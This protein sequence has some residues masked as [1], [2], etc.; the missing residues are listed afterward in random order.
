MNPRPFILPLAIVV[1]WELAGRLGLVQSELMAVPT[2]IARAGFLAI[3]DGSM[4]H[5]T[6]ETAVASVWGTAIGASLGVF[7]GMVFGLFRLSSDLSR[8][9]LEILRPIPSVALIPVSMLV[10]GFGFGMEV[11][12]VAF[13]TF[14]PPLIVTE[15]AVRGIEPQLLQVARV[16]GF[17][18]PRRL[19]KIILPAALPRIF[20]ALRLA[21]AVA[22]VVGVTVEI[23]ANPMGLGHGLIDAHESLHPDRMFA[24]LIWIGLLGWLLNTILLWI[25]YHLLARWMEV[26]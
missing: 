14:W 3:S 11:A 9:T 8:L 18:F 7:L 15:A 24:Y 19:T 4:L 22:L 17:G 10:V 26:G 12:V 6:Y 21:A 20:V 16:L 25:Q 1:V 23:T 2:Q 5:A 13:A